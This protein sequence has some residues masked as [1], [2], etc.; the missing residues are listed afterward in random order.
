MERRKVPDFLVEKFLLG[1]LSREDL[2][3]YDL[4]DLEQRLA[5][6]GRSDREIL[7]RYPPDRMGRMIR[8]RLALE[9]GARHA[10]RRFGPVRFWTLA[11]FAAAAVFLFIFLMQPFVSRSAAPSPGGESEIT[12]IKGIQPGLEIYRK[13]GAGAERLQEGE[14][15]HERDL[16]QIAYISAGEPYGII[17]SVDG[18][19]TVTVHF[20]DSGKESG[21]LENGGPIRLAF[22]YELD[23]APQHETFHFVTAKRSFR[24]DEVVQVSAEKAAIRLPEGF[25]HTSIR[26]DKEP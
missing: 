2:S 16:L 8:T 12:R 25:L 19:G 22:S 1:E 21:A 3:A 4:E 9:P 5:E 20:P 6:I 24:L 23:D 18:R 14:T 7:D 13:T 15:T 26:L 17:F 10:G 11:P